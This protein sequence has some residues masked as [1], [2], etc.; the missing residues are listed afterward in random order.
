MCDGFLIP[1]YNT[2]INLSNYHSNHL[3]NPDLFRGSRIIIVILIHLIFID[4]KTITIETIRANSED[5]EVVVLHTL[6][7]L[8]KFIDTFGLV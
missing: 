4:F 5:S 1:H 3:L 7:G 8:L 6:K 2:H